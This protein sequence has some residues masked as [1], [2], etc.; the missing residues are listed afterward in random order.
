M[1]EDKD[2]D[3]PGRGSVG[4]LENWVFGGTRLSDKKVRVHEWITP[5]GSPLWFKARGQYAVGSVYEVK[6]D[7]KTGG[8]VSLYEHHRRYIGK[9][10]D[11]KLREQLL[12]RHRAGEAELALL[13]RERRD[14]QDDPLEQ[15]IDRLAVLARHVNSGQRT[16]LVGYIIKRLLSSW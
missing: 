7:R 12:V 2:P 1:S 11:D 3:T 4:I 6:L 16:A 15:A 10:Q 14:K 13:Q 8:G 5:D 9:C